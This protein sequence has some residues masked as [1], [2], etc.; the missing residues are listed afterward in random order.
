MEETVCSGCDRRMTLKDLDHS[1]FREVNGRLYCPECLLKMGQPKK[2]RCPNCGT[3]TTATL[4]DGKYACTHCG[5]ELGGRQETGVIPSAKPSGSR[6]RQVDTAGAIPHRPAL[7]HRRKDH[8]TRIL[9]VALSCFIAA[10]LILGALLLK[11]R[12]ERKAAVPEAASKTEVPSKPAP[13]QA[14]RTN[15]EEVLELAQAWVK[16]N[17]NNYEGAIKVYRQAIENVTDPRLKMRLT[18]ELVTVESKLDEKAKTE[19]EQI[20]EL[21]LKLTEAN[22]EID[23][24]KKRLEAAPAV[25]EKTGAKP[26]PPEPA[27][28]GPELTAAEEHNAM[29]QAA[30]RAA[31]AESHRLLS[32][33]KY[34]L[35]M[36][37]LKAVA[38][39][40]ESTEWGKKARDERSRVLNDAYKEFSKIKTRADVL[41]NEGDPDGARQLYA[42]VLG[43]GVPGITQTVEQRLAEVRRAEEATKGPPLSAAVSEQVKALESGEEFD[44][45]EAA[46]R[47]GDLGDKAGVPYLI[48]ALKD[49]KWSVRAR[50]ALSLK[51]LN[52]PRAVPPLIDAL[53]DAEETVRY[54]AHQA[55][56]AITKQDFPA[57]D[58]AKWVAW[59]RQNKAKAPEAPA[60]Q[61]PRKESF[62][63]TV[64][65]RRYNPDI[66]SFVLPRG[67]VLAAGANVELLRGT[68]R[69]CD[70]AVQQ[71][72]KD[73]RASGTVTGLEPNKKLGPGDK[74]T[75]RLP[76]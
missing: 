12:S 59:H 54:D 17:P 63:S 67:V 56:N 74:I 60:P 2:M 41:V 76:K 46:L 40:Y 14:P 58:K 9:A 10:T 62:E 34:G 61:P 13:P 71:V 30:Y 68:D 4:H 57:E 36:K 73:E 21:A 24:L 32:Q 69:I 42:Q 44:R 53:G 47:L 20:K 65:E 66:V 19:R 15:D 29:A 16:K 26:K 33:R 8:T 28:T 52:D 6:D 70:V 7:S 45:S 50:A 23:A 31:I 39:Q 55:L 3:Q 37:T 18:T 43:F 27:D 22:K 38:D 1:S 35:A 25:P 64:L 49:E 51:K 72:T 75:V 5:C 48:A 11:A